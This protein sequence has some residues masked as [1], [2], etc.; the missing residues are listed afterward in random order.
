MSK[1]HVKSGD[2]VFVLTG[3]DKGKRGR[4]LEVLARSGKVIVDGVNIQKKH[5]RPTQTNP[6]GGIVEK[7]GAIDASNV[8]LVCPSCNKPTRV[9]RQRSEN[10]E[11][12]RH[13]KRCGKSID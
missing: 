5:T 4:V 3:D 12:K 7:P 1:V 6:Q 2:R 8:A 13:C 10:G 9:S 11:V